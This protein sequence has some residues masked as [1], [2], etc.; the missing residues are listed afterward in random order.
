MPPASAV[1]APVSAAAPAVAGDLIFVIED[2][3]A[4]LRLVRDLLKSRGHRVAAASTGEEALESLKFL[5]PRLI[6]IDIQ[7]PGMDGLQVARHLKA[8]PG[9]REIPIVALTA[10]AMKG[11][12][13]RAREAGCSGY[14]TKPF[15]STEFLELVA[16][17]LATDRG[18]SAPA[19][20][21]RG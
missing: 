15:G 21:A 2:N 4:N 13:E 14:L 16:S 19:L 10:H 8:R 6:L 18:R 20:G 17:L 1:Q 11:D 12:E 9:T 5:K 7:L 3:V